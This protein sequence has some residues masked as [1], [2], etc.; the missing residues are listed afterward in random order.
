MVFVKIAP[1]R[2][3]RCTSLEPRA[4]IETLLSPN[5]L[6]VLNERINSKSSA[7]KGFCI[8]SRSQTQIWSSLSTAHIYILHEAKHP[9]YPLNRDPRTL[10]SGRQPMYISKMVLCSLKLPVAHMSQGPTSL[11][12]GSYRNHVEFV[13]ESQTYTYMYVCI[14]VYIYTHMHT[15]I[16]A[17]IYIY[18]HRYICICTYISL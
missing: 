16:H 11:E 15:Y 12:G 17:C 18:I 8:R 7:C 5:L 1:K 14:R 10:P 3:L 6:K 9:V 4:L 2:V 13:E